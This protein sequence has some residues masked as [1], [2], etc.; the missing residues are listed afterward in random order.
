MYPQC[1]CHHL[2]LWNA[3]VMSTLLEGY[4]MELNIECA[5]TMETSYS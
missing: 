4:L 2:S 3:L 1:V 5:M